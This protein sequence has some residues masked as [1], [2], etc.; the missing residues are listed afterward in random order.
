MF[1]K[2]LYS[3][4][5]QEERQLAWDQREVELERQLERYEK[6]HNEILN[7]AEKVKQYWKHL[8]IER[9]HSYEWSNKLNFKLWIDF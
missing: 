3:N 5:L 8:L 6:Q 7:S 9:F 4:Q 1:K 2:D